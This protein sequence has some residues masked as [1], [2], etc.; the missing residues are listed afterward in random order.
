MVAVTG[1][2]GILPM[3]NFMPIVDEKHL[4][5]NSSQGLKLRV[6]GDNQSINEVAMVEDSGAGG[7]EMRDYKRNSVSVSSWQRACFHS[8]VSQPRAD[9]HAE[10][11]HDHNWHSGRSDAKSE[12]GKSSKSVRIDEKFIYHR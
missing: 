7:G 11:E 2:G 5:R 12:S 9:F 4:I 8:A 3:T 10:H 6:G 1:G